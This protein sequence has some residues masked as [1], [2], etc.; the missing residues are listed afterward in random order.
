MDIIT[1]IEGAFARVEAHIKT[2]FDGGA[3]HQQ[4]HAKD[5][6]CVLDAAKSGGPIAV[7][8]DLAAYDI[9]LAELN[10]KVHELTAALEESNG[11]LA[12]MQSNVD[13]MMTE[14]DQAKAELAAALQQ[15]NDV[16]S[17]AANPVGG[18]IA[19]QGDLAQQK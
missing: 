19:S 6:Q 8:P 15:A 2:L 3:P 11:K 5:L 18:R 1:D 7:S 13:A 14:R 17:A 10:T 9:K 12:N 16:L 4:A